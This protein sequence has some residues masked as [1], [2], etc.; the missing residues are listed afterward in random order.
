MKTSTKL[1]LAGCGV[2]AVSGYIAYEKAQKIQA[3]FDKMDIEPAF[4]RNFDFNLSSGLVRFDLDVKL[5]NT[6]DDDLYLTGLGVSRLK[7]LIIYYK[8]IK[9]SN[10]NLT[11]N[12]ISIPSKNSLIIHNIHVVSN[13]L[14]VIKAGAA[15]PAG[16]FASFQDFSM[17]NIDCEIVVEVLGREYTIGR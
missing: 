5:T 11:V 1:I 4:M 6:T 17:K 15:D 3:I 16:V 2:L 14:E 7:Q 9:I 12:A 10:A 8:D 13:L